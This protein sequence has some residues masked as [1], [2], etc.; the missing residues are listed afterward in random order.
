[1]GVSNGSELG[2][3]EGARVKVD[4]G[5]GGSDGSELGVNEGEDP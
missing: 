3:N 1:M 2:V 4:A 5:V